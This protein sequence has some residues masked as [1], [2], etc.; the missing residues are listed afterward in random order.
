MANAYHTGQSAQTGQLP[1]SL[2]EDN[3]VYTEN[4]RAGAGLVLW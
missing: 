2:R 3:P 1:R 4:Q